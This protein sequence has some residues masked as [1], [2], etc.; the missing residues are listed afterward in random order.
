V[1]KMVVWVAAAHAETVVAVVAEAEANI[2]EN[3][4]SGGGIDSDNCGN[5][6]ISGGC[7]D[8]RW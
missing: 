3:R 2:S 5:I 6:G 8:G 4:D 7:D 1:T